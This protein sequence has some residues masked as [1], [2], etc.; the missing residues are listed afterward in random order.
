MAYRI[1]EKCIA[2]GCCIGECPNGAIRDGEK[3]CWIKTERCT[4]CVG[5]HEKP[6]CAIQCPIGAPELDPGHVESREELLEK[7]KR[8]HPKK[9]AMYV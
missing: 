3:Y 4:E 1:S 5:F 7:F 9:A 6:E 2:C 8:L